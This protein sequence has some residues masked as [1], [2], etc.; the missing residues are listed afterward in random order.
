V[1]LNMD[2]PWNPAVL[3]QRIGRV[4]RLGQK[5]AVRVVN[6]VARGSIEE[7]ML[8]VLKFKK[9]LFQGVL[10]GGEKEVFLGGS[11]LTKFMESVEAATA[12]IPTSTPEEEAAD[13]APPP[14]PEPEPQA[15]P[16][17]GKKA[18]PAPPEEEDH[19]PTPTAP[20]SPWAG[21]LQV[22]AALL[23]QLAA[24]PQAPTAGSRAP[25]LVRRDEQTGETYLRLPVP[26]PEVL[27]QALGALQALL[28]SM[29][30]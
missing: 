14:E 9:S 1:V 30:K 3:E 16:K 5:Q 28:Q 20:V 11:R 17:S 8:E 27:N 22:G 12:A 13:T 23:Q 21:L 2:L 7:G 25:S 10:D 26:P 19:R 15:Q 18:E 6:F 24:N 4:H 29:Q